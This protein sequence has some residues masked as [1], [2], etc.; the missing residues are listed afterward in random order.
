MKRAPW[1]ILSLLVGILIVGA[2][3]LG[4]LNGE[5][6]ALKSENQ[7][8]RK[9]V[10]EARQTPQPQTQPSQDFLKDAE[11]L[12]EPKPSPH[13]ITSASGVR[14]NSKC[15]YFQNSKGRACGAIEGRACKL[16]GG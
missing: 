2:F 8:L 15:R 6:A 3:K 11:P 5:N 13:W 4:G 12:P 9:V 7:T 14:H 10:E 16:C 1:I